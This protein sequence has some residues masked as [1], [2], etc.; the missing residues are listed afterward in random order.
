M[1]VLGCISMLMKSIGSSVELTLFSLKL[2]VASMSL[3]ETV[4][5]SSR[6][7]FYGPLHK[8]Q[9]KQQLFEIF[10]AGYRISPSSHPMHSLA[11]Q[12]AA[13]YRNIRYMH[14][15]SHH[16]SHGEEQE[17]E[18]EFRSLGSHSAEDHL[19]DW[20]PG[21]DLPPCQDEESSGLELGHSQELPSFMKLA[22]VSGILFIHNSQ[23]QV[24]PT[25]LAAFTN[26]N[27]GC[28]HVIHQVP[29]A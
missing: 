11:P 3:K 12:F 22:N 18:E 25:T 29:T 9:Y 16:D 5:E 20:D 2:P 14:E 27:T 4:L 21:R 1:L 8:I 28:V 7:A 23:T 13:S 24:F 6:L 10:R 26:N 17:G 15:R 19:S